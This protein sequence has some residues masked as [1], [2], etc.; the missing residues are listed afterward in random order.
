MQRCKWSQLHKLAAA[1]TCLMY[2][3]NQPTSLHQPLSLSPTG[4]WN[5]AA[6]AADGLTSVISQRYRYNYCAIISLSAASGNLPSAGQHLRIERVL[7]AAYRLSASIVYASG[8]ARLKSARVC[9]RAQSLRACACKTG[10]MVHVNLL[11][12]LL[13][14]SGKQFVKTS[15]SFVTSVEQMRAEHRSIIFC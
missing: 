8:L 14:N 2:L 13:W 4:N 7:T 10:L 1:A 15:T 5:L 3:H 11:Q 6:L 9:E 12:T